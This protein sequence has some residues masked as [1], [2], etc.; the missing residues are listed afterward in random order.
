MRNISTALLV[1]SLLFVSPVMAGA[2]HDHGSGGHSHGAISGGEI[3]KKATVK[4]KSLVESGKLEKSWG[5]VEADGASTKNDEWVVTYK[6]DK[7]SDAAKRTLY[8]FFSL[9]GTYIATNFTGK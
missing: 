1:S 8:M 5:D 3:I 6:N 4:V 9:D 2:G 7:A